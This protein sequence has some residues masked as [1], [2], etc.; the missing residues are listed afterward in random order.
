MERTR[1]A[2]VVFC[3]VLL[4][5]IIRAV[6]REHIRVEYSMAWFGATL[7]LLILSLWEGALETL[8]GWLGVSQFSELLLVLAGIVFLFTFFRQS[9]ELSSLKDHSIQAGQKIGL[10]EWELRKQGERVEALQQK[11]NERDAARGAED[12]G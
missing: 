3:V 6:R 1:W 5:Q 8:G 12:E 4:A 9:V 11:L 7:V 2:M 10:L